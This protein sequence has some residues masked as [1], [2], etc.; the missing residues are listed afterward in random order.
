MAKRRYKTYPGLSKAQRAL[1]EE[2]KWISGRLAFGAKCIT[3]GNTGSLAREDLESIANF[4]LC[5]AATR[6]DPAKDVKFSTYA[7]KTARGYIEHALRD[8]SRLV[9]TPRWI[10]KHKTQILSMLQENMSY[11]EIA[12]KLGIDETKVLECQLSENNYHISYDSQPEDWVDTD[13][14]YNPDEA[15]VLLLS[16]E[17]TKAFETLSDSEM[18]LMIDFIEGSSLPEDQKQ[19]ASDKFNNLR[20]IAHGIK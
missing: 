13:F 8:Y 10:A 18:E 1:V 11:A 20:E 9:K 5:V 2:H 16:P 12:D 19:W 15:K 17:L 7:W 4:A 14:I 6:F 3:G